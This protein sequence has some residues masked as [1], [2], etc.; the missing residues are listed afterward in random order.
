MTN[1]WRDVRFGFRLLRKNPCFAAFAVLAL[2]LG[3]GA[4]TAIYSIVYATLLEPLPY[5]HP[6]EI[7]MVG[8]KIQGERNGVAAGDYLDWKREST[9]FQGLA[10]WTGAGVNLATASDPEQVQAWRAAPGF[11]TVMG[12]SILL[13]RDFLPEEG[14][15]GKDHVTILTYR[16]WWDRFG[17]A[18]A[19][20]GTPIRLDGEPYTVVGVLGPGP[21]DRGREKLGI[22]LSFKPEEINHDFHWLLV[23][24]RLKPGVS[25]SQAQADMDLVTHNIAA[26]S[27]KSKGWGAS[28]EPLHNDFLNRNTRKSLWLLLGAVALVFLIACANVA[29]LLL[30]R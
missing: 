20:V 16:F 13:G 19:I 12:Q 29:N 24:G 3:I 7:V 11:F 22:A 28:V 14:E 23:S 2:A 27:P 1:L 9:G 4:N 15:V 18:R 10:A 30:A 25:L 8:S 17:G 26:A 5:Y 21:L 6:N